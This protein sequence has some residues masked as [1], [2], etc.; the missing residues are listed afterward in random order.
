MGIAK[1]IY[2]SIN[3]TIQ[4]KKKL[5]QVNVPPNYT[6]QLELIES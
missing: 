4:K 2:F 5:Q 1:T 3:V 6:T